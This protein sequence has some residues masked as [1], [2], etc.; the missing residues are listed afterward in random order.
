MTKGMMMF[1]GGVGTM[2]LLVVILIIFSICNGIAQKNLKKK[3]D[4]IYKDD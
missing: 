1:Y 3:L 4:S 2:V